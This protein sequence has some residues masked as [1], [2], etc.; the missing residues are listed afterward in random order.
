MKHFCFFLW[1][2][3]GLRQRFT[4]ERFLGIFIDSWIEMDA[5]NVNSE[6]ICSSVEHSDAVPFAGQPSVSCAE[7][8]ELVSP[9]RSGLSPPQQ[10]LAITG[11]LGSAAATRSSSL[12]ISL[13]AL[14]RAHQGIAPS[15]SLPSTSWQTPIVASTG[16]NGLALDM[17]TS[18]CTVTGLNEPATTCPPTSFVPDPLMELGTMAYPPTSIVHGSSACNLD[19]PPAACEPG[20]TSIRDFDPAQLGSENLYTTEV[21]ADIAAYVEK[22]FRKP[23]TSEQFRAMGKHSPRPKTDAMVVPTVDPAV[24]SWVGPRFPHTT[25]KMLSA[26]QLELLTSAGPLT[27]LWNDCVKSASEATDNDEVAVPL[28]VVMDTIQ[29]TLVL[30]GNANAMISQRRRQTILSAGNRDMS[31]YFVNDPPTAG[32]HLFGENFST[33]IVERVRSQTALQKASTMLRQART[34][35]GS[36]R[37]HQRSSPRSWIRRRPVANQRPFRSGAWPHGEGGQANRFRSGR[38]NRGNRPMSWTRPTGAGSKPSEA[39]S[40]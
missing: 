3:L 22:F 40:Q 26:C 36:H 28:E 10:A 8:P 23:L 18:G 24:Q 29:R 19:V 38:N 30:L 35:A 37:E 16:T 39:R 11:Q 14:P 7:L 17:R 33:Q 2:P 4:S 5:Q 34:D 12:G 1:I 32:T 9:A 21:P 6:L 27:S 20:K 15:T 13:A 31:Q 25:D